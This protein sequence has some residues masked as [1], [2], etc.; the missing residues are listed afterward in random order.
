VA[1]AI[2]LTLNPAGV[3][4]PLKRAVATATQ[5]IGTCIRA[6]EADDLAPADLQAEF[7]A[8]RF[9]G[10]DLSIGERRAMIH[11]WLFAKGFQD[12]V[13]GVREMLEEAHFYLAMI[14]SDPGLTTMAKIEADIAAKRLAAQKPSFPLL[15]EQVNAGLREPI[16]FE[17]EYLSFQ[18]VRNCLEHRAGCVLPKDVDP[19]SG[20]LTLH[21]PRLKAFYK[22]G[23]E[24]IE[25]AGGEQIDPGPNGAHSEGGVPILV[26]RV[27]RSRE[28]CVGENVEITLQHF[29]EIAMACH[30][31][32]DDL[33]SKLP[34]LDPI[35]EGHG[36]HGR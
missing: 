19:T 14:K 13:R 10:L 22:R 11:N 8:Y 6:L 30:L 5:V 27:M 34:Q 9:D 17:A 7:M 1:E 16:I 35:D 2:T 21:F 31:F 28:Y 36:T 33:M 12:L 3:G 25:I 32:A 18:K 26:K 23:S 24:E 4:D 15:L 20:L 29:A